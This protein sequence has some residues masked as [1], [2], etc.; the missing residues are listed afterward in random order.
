MAGVAQVMVIHGRAHIFP[1][2]PFMD[3]ERV[4]A[5]QTIAGELIPHFLPFRMVDV[6]IFHKSSFRVIPVVESG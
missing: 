5:I 1:A 3:A 6:E 2:V 4:T